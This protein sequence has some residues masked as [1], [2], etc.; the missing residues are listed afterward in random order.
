MFTSGNS[1]SL[2][3]ALDILHALQ[4][5]GATVFYN[6]HIYNI[7]FCIT[8]IDCFLSHPEYTEIG[9]DEELPLG[10]EFQE[11]LRCFIDPHGRTP[12]AKYSMAE[13]LVKQLL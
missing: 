7:Y 2:T 9:G 13:K 11:H 12:E 3:A 1:I 10:A 6:I 8:L 4:S 5:F